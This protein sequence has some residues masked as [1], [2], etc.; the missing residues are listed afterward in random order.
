MVASC[1]GLR[2]F[3]IMQVKLDRLIFAMPDDELEQFCRLWVEKKSN[4]FEIKRYGASGDKGRDV[5][6]F[7]AAERHDG[8]W[9]N[10][11]C[12]QYRKALDMANGL[13]AV[14]KVLYWAAQGTFT[15][16]RC[17][18]FVAPKGLAGKLRELLDKPADFKKRLIADWDTACANRI[19]QGQTLALD[20]KVAAAIDVFDFQRLSVIDIDDMLADPNVKPLLFEKYGVDPGEYPPGVVPNVVQASE[21]PYIQALVDAYGERESTAFPDHNLVL[22]HAT[23]GPDLKM[24][25]E[26]YFEAEG[27]QKFYR[28]NTS[29]TVIDMFRKDIRFGVNETW[30]AEA[31]DTLGRVN[32]VM[33][34]AATIQPGGPLSR[35]GYIRVKQGFCHHFVNDGELSWKPEP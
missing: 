27:F 12:K 22:A 26:R 30:K 14:G 11:Q 33:T 5:V 35:Y 21:L 8:V 9:D 34:Q 4:Y 19:I 3:Q 6:G 28:D 13:L 31:K 17:F 29:P 20:S 25:R 16:P 7:A 18:Y 10:Y 32:A 23:H 1:R 24:H 15:V 2:Q